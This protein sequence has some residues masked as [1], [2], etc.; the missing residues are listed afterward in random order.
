MKNPRE[1]NLY[2]LICLFTFLFFLI[3]SVLAWNW[4]NPNGFIGVI[5]FLKLWF[6]LGWIGHQ[7]S[8][9]INKMLRRAYF[10][11]NRVE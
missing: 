10:K 11:K 2:G 5:I 7:M 3:S 4:V 9:W 8:V 6:I 1:A